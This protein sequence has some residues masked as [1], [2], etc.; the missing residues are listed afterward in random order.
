MWFLKPSGEKWEQKKIL[1]T[2]K[3]KHMY[4]CICIHTYINFFVISIFIFL[5]FFISSLKMWNEKGRKAG[6]MMKSNG[7]E[8]H[9]FFFTS[10]LKMEKKIKAFPISE[11]D[12]FLKKN[13]INPVIH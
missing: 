3:K 4:I 9:Y 1:Y 8:N 11:K 13:K 5:F 7:W 12:S 2:L 6:D 10:A